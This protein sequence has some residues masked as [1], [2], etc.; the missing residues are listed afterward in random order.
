MG[1]GKFN[2]HNNVKNNYINKKSEVINILQFSVYTSIINMTI[3]VILLLVSCLLLLH[4]L[5]SFSRVF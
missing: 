1:R 3:T 5:R 2:F 4:I